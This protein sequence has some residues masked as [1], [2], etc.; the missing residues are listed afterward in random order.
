LFELAQTKNKQKKNSIK[1]TFKKIKKEDFKIFNFFF[2]H[3]Y[4]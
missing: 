3:I 2:F 1:K 4:D